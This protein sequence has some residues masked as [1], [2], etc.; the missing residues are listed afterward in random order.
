MTV[1]AILCDNVLPKDTNPCKNLKEH[2]KSECAF[3]GCGVKG[4]YKNSGFYPI[5]LH[6]FIA[7]EVGADIPGE[8]A[9]FKGNSTFGGG[10]FVFCVFPCMN[11]PLLSCS[12]RAVHHLNKDDMI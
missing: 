12:Q 11:P 8:T 2:T 10:A 4:A 3:R 7:C 9:N 1:F 6:P 5:F